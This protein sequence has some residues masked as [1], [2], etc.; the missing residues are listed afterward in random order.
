MNEAQG[1][2]L[3]G[4]FKWFCDWFNGAFPKAASGDYGPVYDEKAAV[5]FR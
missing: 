4:R 2:T 3:C 5:C 1:Y